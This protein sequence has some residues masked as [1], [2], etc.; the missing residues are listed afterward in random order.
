MILYTRVTHRLV[1]TTKHT[2]E[3][4]DFS[5]RLASCSERNKLSTTIHRRVHPSSRFDHAMKHLETHLKQYMYLQFDYTGNRHKHS[6]NGSRLHVQFTYIML[7]YYHQCTIINTM[8]LLY[9][10]RT[11]KYKINVYQ[12]ALIHVILDNPWR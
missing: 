2:R 3:R 5:R 11:Q 8:Q 1:I 9:N 7:L 12:H 6:T 10:T 4:Y